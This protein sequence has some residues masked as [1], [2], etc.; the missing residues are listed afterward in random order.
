MSISEV[1]Y[2]VNVEHQST[3]QRVA[4]SSV[5]LPSQNSGFRPCDFQKKK[6]HNLLQ[7]RLLFTFRNTL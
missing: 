2:G 7:I 6:Q 3:V 1:Q 4:V 5:M